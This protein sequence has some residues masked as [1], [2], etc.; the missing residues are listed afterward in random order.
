MVKN[1]FFQILSKNIKIKIV[2]DSCLLREYEYVYQKIKKI[3]INVLL[4]LPLRPTFSPR[5][6]RIFYKSKKW[7]FSGWVFCTDS[8][9]ILYADANGP[10]LAEKN[11]KKHFFG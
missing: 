6:P 9:Y 5:F 11:L 1:F 3:E 2:L 8:E 7:I 10:I 4:W